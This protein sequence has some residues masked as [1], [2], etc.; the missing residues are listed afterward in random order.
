MLIEVRFH[1][2]G[3]SQDN[4]IVSVENELGASTVNTLAITGPAGAI[5]GISNIT[6]ATATFSVPIPTDSD[7]AYLYGTYSFVITANDPDDSG[8]EFSETKTFN[9]QDLSG[10]LLIEAY[11]DPFIKR[12]VVE[13]TTDYPTGTVTRDFVVV[14]PRITGE[15]NVADTS[16]T[17]ATGSITMIRSTGVAYNN[18]TYRVRPSAE[19]ET[20]TI[21]GDWDFGGVYEYTADDVEV[22]VKY[23]SCGLLDCVHTK[24]LEIDNQACISGGFSSLPTGTK[25]LYQQL[26]LYL[27]MYNNADACRDADKVNY[28]REKIEGLVGT[29]NCTVSTTIPVNNTVY[30]SGQS[31]YEIWLGEGNSGSEEDFLNTLNPVGNWTNVPAADFDPDFE[32]DT[33]DPLRYRVT[34]D[35]LQFAGKFVRVAASDPVSPFIVLLST[36]D[37]GNV[38]L[39]APIP[40]YSDSYRTVGSFCKQSTT[41]VMYADVALAGN[42]SRIISG[43][44]PWEGVLTTLAY[45][46]ERTFTP[47]TNAQISGNPNINLSWSK[48][49]NFFYIKG[50]FTCNA[51]VTGGGAIDLITV[52][53]FLD[54]LGVTLT[55]GV[56]APIFATTG[57]DE[58]EQI[59]YAETQ[60][61]LALYNSDPVAYP[62]WAA[63]TP[64]FYMQIPLM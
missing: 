24:L 56:K 33:D 47:F 57:S 42:P 44:I 9:F 32:S 59:G 1:T 60:G 49:S 27:G 21:T 41:W 40:V 29:C 10:D 36:F 43:K 28:Y 15:T 51:V 26:Q 39:E 50:S 34:R 20:S 58:F 7:D 22:T 17:A 64:S 5:S 37:P 19:L 13:D 46:F 6:G 3:T 52:D 18:V 38:V 48:D 12:L 16:I 35:G 54:D 63:L 45:S 62:S 8:V 2:T 23:D 30:L 14:S 53:T 31:A 25:E 61:G 11:A 4:I 55:S